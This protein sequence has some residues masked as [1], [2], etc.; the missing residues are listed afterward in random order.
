MARLIAQPT[1]SFT[2]RTNGRNNRRSSWQAIQNGRL[3]LSKYDP[4]NEAGVS[5]S[6]PEM[7]RLG[8][9]GLVVA[10]ALLTMLMGA[11]VYVITGL[12]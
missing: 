6:E 2:C 10:M 11:L 12:Q 4:E 7:S 3:F 5:E 9:I 8:A 1:H